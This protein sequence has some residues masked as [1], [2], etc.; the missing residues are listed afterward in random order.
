ML[1]V[2]TG[3][4]LGLEA[5]SP[6]WSWSFVRVGLRSCSQGWTF[7]GLAKGLCLSWGSQQEGPE[8]LCPSPA[9]MPPKC[10]E[11]VA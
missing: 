11:V 4:S 7:L 1:C 8:W 5:W 10:S 3:C 9:H 6:A 2:W